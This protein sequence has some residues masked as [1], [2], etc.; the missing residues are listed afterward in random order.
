VILSGACQPRP[1]LYAGRV[2]E[3]AE[4]IL[5]ARGLAIGGEAIFMPPCLFDKENQE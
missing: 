2:S 5:T 4:R 1:K 3:Q